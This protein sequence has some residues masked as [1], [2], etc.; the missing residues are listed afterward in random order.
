MTKP[1][2]ADRKFYSRHRP[3]RD[4]EDFPDERPQPPAQASVRDSLDR[5]GL[6]HAKAAEVVTLTAAGY[7]IPQ[8]SSRLNVS[9]STVILLQKHGR[10]ILRSLL[11]LG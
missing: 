9:E 1:S 5:L 2:K 7:T 10:T 8:I 3:L 4:G 11:E 6:V